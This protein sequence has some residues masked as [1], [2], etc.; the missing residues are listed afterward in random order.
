MTKKAIRNIMICFCVFIFT[1]IVAYIA[2][3]YSYNL[4]LEKASETIGNPDPLSTVL[5]PLKE[6]DLITVTHY[7]ARY[8]GEHLAIYAATNDEEEFLYTLDARI[9]DISKEE[10]E[11]L[12]QGIILPDKQSL[13]SFEEDFTS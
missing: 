3:M 6:D 13:A 4:T 12:I 11:G 9:E 5:N 8:N 1:I 10:L 2:S 7:V